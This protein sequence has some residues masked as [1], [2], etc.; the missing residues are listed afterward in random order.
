LSYVF[1]CVN[2]LGFLLFQP[3]SFL[4]P[5]FVVIREKSMRDQPSPVSFV[6]GAIAMDWLH[7]LFSTRK[8]F[9]SKQK[10]DR[11]RTLSCCCT[12]THK[13]KESK[14]TNTHRHNDVVS[15]LRVYSTL[16]FRLL[17][18]YFLGRIVRPAMTT[19]RAPDQRPESNSRVKK[20][21]CSTILSRE[22]SSSHF[23]STRRANAVRSKRRASGLRWCLW[24]G[25][26]SFPRLLASNWVPKLGQQQQQ[27]TEHKHDEGFFTFTTHQTA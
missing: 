1:D 24:W 3:V 5:H 8:S 14:L 26:W 20:E 17:Y 11:T 4:P 27:K 9:T 23:I 6:L 15:L 2:G 16:E 19:D 25:V 7:F 10:R 22:T 12:T 18:F 13:S 21:S